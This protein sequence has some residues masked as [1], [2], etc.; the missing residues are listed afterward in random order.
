[1]IKEKTKLKERG[2]YRNVCKKK[3]KVEIKI[4]KTS[5]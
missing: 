3:G 1:V 2:A 4:S 5:R